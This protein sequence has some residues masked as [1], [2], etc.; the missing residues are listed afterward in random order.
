MKRLFTHVCVNAILLIAAF[1]GCISFSIDQ[2]KSSLRSEVITQKFA[3]SEVKLQTASPQFLLSKNNTHLVNYSVAPHIKTIYA[4][5][6]TELNSF[7]HSA[8]LP[9]Y[10][11]TL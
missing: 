8:I 11:N 3:T 1:F 7:N 9:Y 5:T 4:T 6:G 2:K 10:I